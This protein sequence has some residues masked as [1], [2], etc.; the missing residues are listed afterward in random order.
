MKNVATFALELSDAYSTHRY[1]GGWAPTIK[2]LRKLKWNDRE[3][4]AFIR[5]K[6]TRWAG[7]W[8]NKNGNVNSADVLRYIQAH[9]IDEKER[10]LLVVGTF[11][12]RP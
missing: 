3:I 2:A 11:G 10:V 6:H 4:E 8:A 1:T 5:S 9:N 7:D 12:G